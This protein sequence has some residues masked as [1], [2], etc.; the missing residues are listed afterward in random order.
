MKKPATSKIEDTEFERSSGNVFV[1]LG[2][3]Q[4]EELKTKLVLAVRLNERIKTLH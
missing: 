2:P 1:D 3:A 4:P